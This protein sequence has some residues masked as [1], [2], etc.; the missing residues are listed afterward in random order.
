MTFLLKLLLTIFTTL[1]VGIVLIVM[2]EAEPFSL[3][4]IFS[5]FSD[6]TSIFPTM[7]LLLW[8]S[9]AVIFTAEYVVLR[10]HLIGS[11]KFKELIYAN[12]EA[13]LGLS[14]LFFLMLPLLKISWLPIYVIKASILLLTAFIGL[15]EVYL[16]VHFIETHNLT[17]NIAS[18]TK[19]LSYIIIP[20]Y[21][22]Y[23]F[24]I[25]LLI[26]T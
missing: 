10:P 23:M 19:I 1:L 24:T 6:Y 14:V 26:N 8:V 17:T 18:V 3:L 9:R 5:D 15:C 22:A 4:N 16:K 20:T 21:I 25:L 7:F 2:G 12:L 13:F 11:H